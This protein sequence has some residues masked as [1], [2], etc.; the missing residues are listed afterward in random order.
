MFHYFIYNNNICHQCT[1]VS[2]FLAYNKFLQMDKDEKGKRGGWSN[3]NYEV[4]EGKTHKWME[5][6]FFVGQCVSRCSCNQME[7]VYTVH[8]SKPFIVAK[9]HIKW[10]YVPAQWAVPTAA[11][12]GEILIFFEILILYQSIVGSN[13]RWWFKIPDMC[14]WLD[15]IF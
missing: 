14:G 10:K 3:P 6:S 9:E 13:W 1:R 4:T 15:H 12:I 8:Y 7:R 5:F 2:K 11:F